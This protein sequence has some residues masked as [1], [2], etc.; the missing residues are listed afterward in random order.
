MGTFFVILLILG[1]GVL[2][3]LAFDAMKREKD[4][5]QQRLINMVKSRRRQADTM[6]SSANDLTLA[7]TRNEKHPMERLRRELW[8]AGLKI[9]LSRYLGIIGGAAVMMMILCLPLTRNPFILLIAALI[10]AGAPLMALRMM[11]NQRRAKIEQQLPEA[12]NL[13]SSTLR[14]GYSLLQAMQVICEEMD[15]PIAEEFQL[16]LDELKVGLTFEHALE[17]MGKRIASQDVDLLVTATSIQYR[18]GGNL[19]EILD[20]IGES[21]R[22][23][24]QFRSEVSSLTAE[25]RLSGWILFAL[26]LFLLAFMIIY[27]RNYVRPLLTEPIGQEM[28]AGAIIM[29]FIGGLVI[30]KMIKIDY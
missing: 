3:Y 8:K 10:G 12:L 2:G 6:L 20:T 23:R 24:F 7:I 11:Q 27:N 30:R 14:S 1:A 22:Q 28:L 18:L 25:A 13:S 4:Q 26:P 16:V 21:I 29:Q 19:A 17:R 15:A 9:P 5:S